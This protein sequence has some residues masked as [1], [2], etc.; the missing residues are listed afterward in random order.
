MHELINKKFQALLAEGQ[1]VLSGC[2]WD[3][4]EMQRW[5]NEIDYNRFRTELMNLLRR[6]C[7]KDSDHYQ[8]LKRLSE[9][10]ASC[11]HF[12]DCF[13]I[14][15]AAQRD[16]DD[17]FLFDIRTLVAA[18]L[19]GDFIDQAEVLIEGG[20]HHPAASLA[21][22]VLEDALRK[23]CVSKGITVPQKTTIGQLNADLARAGAYNKLVQKRIIALA[24]IRNNADHGHFEEFTKEDV[25]D[26]VRWL[27]KFTADYLE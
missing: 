27:R 23:L 1:Q 12:T 9:A 6:V 11:A 15:Q 17:G 3:G 16:Y 13:G 18:E 26:M 25:E 10:K 8:E 19:L 21:G 14:L 7:G 20:Y 4:E 24:D 22:A 2:G 5:P